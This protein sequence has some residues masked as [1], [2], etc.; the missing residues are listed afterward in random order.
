MHRIDDGGLVWSTASLA[1]AALGFLLW[2][3]MTFYEWRKIGGNR[4]LSFRCFI[5]DDTPSIVIAIISTLM[6]YFGIPSMGTWKALTDVIGFVPKLDF[7]SAA[8]TGY[9]S[10]SIAMKLRNIAR[11]LNG[12]DP[13][14]GTT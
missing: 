12:D 5:A 9:L 14:P 1:G 7:I 10:S 11:K 4:T 13:P 6:L 3:T 8:A 2:I